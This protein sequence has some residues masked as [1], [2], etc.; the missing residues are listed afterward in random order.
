VGQFVVAA[1]DSGFR[2]LFPDEADGLW[3]QRL[4]V[5]VRAG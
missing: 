2:V 4:A 1:G 5:G 3:W